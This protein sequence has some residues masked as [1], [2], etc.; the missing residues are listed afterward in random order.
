MLKLKN[1]ILCALFLT[2]LIDQLISVPS[3]TISSNLNVPSLISRN[4]DP[5]E[6]KDDGFKLLENEE[7]KK[8]GTEALSAE[9]DEK[10]EQMKQKRFVKYF[11]K[12][13]EKRKRSDDED[14]THEHATIEVVAASAGVLR[15]EAADK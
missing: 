4:F 14:E 11:G 9:E 12:I 7:Q 15:S 5:V 8:S 10:N 3:G 2:F 6:L 1:I 13:A